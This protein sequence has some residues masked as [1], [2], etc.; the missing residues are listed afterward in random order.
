MKKTLFAALL[1]AVFANPAFPAEPETQTKEVLVTANR[2]ERKDT[3]TT[4]ASE[5]HSAA[6]I[7]ASGAESLYDF[8]LQHSS[9]NVLPS[10]GNR[11]T[12]LLDMRGYGAEGGFQ[13]IVITVDGQ[14]LNN[15]DLSSQLIGAIPLSNIDRI[16][17]TKG[18]GSVLYG[19]GAVA[20]TIQIHTKSRTGVTVR[21]SAGNYGSLSGYASAGISEQYF[22]LSAS[23]AHDSNDGYGKKDVTGNRD[24]F[25]SNTQNAKL[26]LKPA[27]NL[28]FSLEATSSRIDTRY[29]NPLSIAQFKA[30]PRQ[31]GLNALGL[32]ELTHQGLDTDQWRLGVEYAV[33]NNWKLSATHYQEDKVSDYINFNNRLDYDYRSNDLSLSYEDE[34]FSSILGLQNFEGTRDATNN[35][36]SKDNVAAFL[37]GEYRIADW[38]LSAGA[39]HEKIDYEYNPAAGNSQDASE[40]LDAWDIGLNYR[41]NNATSLFANYN[42]AYQAPDIDR[43][44]L[45]GGSFNGFISPEKSKT[46]NLGLNHVTAVN[47]LKVTAFYVDLNN[48][49][50]FNP[51][52]FAN[53]NLDRTH[54]YGVEIQDRWD[55]T[56]QLSSS[57][58][59]T[60][61]RAR[62]DHEADGAG[63]FEGKDLP[64]VPKNSINASLNYRPIKPVNINLSH[65]WRSSSYVIGDFANSLNE[66]QDDYHSTNMAVSYQ[67]REFQWFAAVS[68]LFEHKNGLYVRSDFPVAN[69]VVVYP[70]D[71]ARTFRIGVK[72]DL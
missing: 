68:N 37:Q 47:R 62:I 71:F 16:E 50:Y 15:I 57:I 26:K 36:T 8:L 72:V 53:T 9:V 1:P 31:V 24:D 63:S 5:I 6:E 17:I 35:S 29:V 54:K 65:T 49:I 2:F 11:A 67:W 23:V 41:F 66:K 19:D 4:Y 69:D 12:P 28:S 27:D 22:D 33:S 52:T 58:I 44:F 60:Y 56:E 43:F 7:E 70:S 46:F 30:D 40:K 10:A 20:G 3:E 45:F 21:G 42:R 32:A 18:S 25:T 48:E 14:R 13:N 38:T 34:R 64:G 39:R 51:F 61:T 55:I 59:Y